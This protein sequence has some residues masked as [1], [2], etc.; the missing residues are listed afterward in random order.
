MKRSLVIAPR[1]TR[2]RR[3]AL[4][5]A[6]G[7]AAP[8]DGPARGPLPHFGL[9]EPSDPRARRKSALISAGLHA[10]F[11]VGLLL[12]ALLAPP[13]LIERIIPV[14]LMPAAR[15]IELPG[16]NAEP[17]PSGPRSVGARRPSAAALAAAGGLTA[18]Q[19]RALREA[20]REAAR[21]SIQ[22]M[23]VEAERQP[24]LPS[25]VERRPAQAERLAARAAAAVSPHERV[26]MKELEPVRIDP[27]DLQALDLDLDGP[28]EIDA[29]S[30][31]DLS[32][33]A[34][35]ESLGALGASDYSGSVNP[36][37]AVP[38]AVLAGPGNGGL[39]TGLAEGFTGGS[40]GFGSG[41]GSGGTGQVVGAVRCLESASVQRYLDRLRL[42]T[43]QRWTVP[44]GVPPNAEVVLRFA[45]DASGM[46]TDT[47]AVLSSRTGNGTGTGTDTGN[48]TGNSDTQNA[49]T[50]D[51]GREQN[52]AL[53]ESAVQALRSAS[54]FPPMTDANRCLTDKRIVL[55][56]TVP[57]P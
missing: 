53:A 57:N 15:P 37:A 6:G 20:A 24:V 45:V 30:L 5:F 14:Q 41:A 29:Q 32:A 31:G 11:L 38:G 13:E 18:E 17:A 34:A 1:R 22:Q 16:T 9:P 43:Y 19:A 2:S 28:R 23:Q 49:E 36:S 27:A 7:L 8:A 26:E 56:F 47:Q 44:N 4:A 52:P 55:T 54:P 21:R 25:Q 3:P 10:T 48:D 51:A 42:R 12:A 46:A 50:Q 40:G 35:L 33:P 39:D